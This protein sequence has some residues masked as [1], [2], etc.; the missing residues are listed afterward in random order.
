M[1]VGFVSIALHAARLLSFRLLLKGRNAIGASKFAT[2]ERVPGLGGGI[3]VGL[4]CFGGIIGGEF[5]NSDD[6]IINLDMGVAMDD[7]FIIDIADAIDDDASNKIIVGND[8]IGASPNVNANTLRLLAMGSEDEDD[9]QCF[10]KNAAATGRDGIR[11]GNN[12]PPLRQ[13]LNLA[14]N[15]Q[16]AM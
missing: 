14:K 7:S 6:R 3:H 13:R 12:Q 10:D 9:W 16:G 5:L 8:A 15:N 2:L 11:Q 1:L 4:V